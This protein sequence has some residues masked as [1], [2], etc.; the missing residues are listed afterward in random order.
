MPPHRRQMDPSSLEALVMLRLNKSLWSAKT[1]QDIIDNKKAK[2]KRDAL[3]E[4]HD[5]SDEEEEEEV[6]V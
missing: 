4:V 2:A 5:I 1:V 6:I 3:E